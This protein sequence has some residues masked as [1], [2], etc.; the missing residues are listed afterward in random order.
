VRERQRESVC[1]PVG[2]VGM[3]WEHPQ[4]PVFVLRWSQARDAV[5]PVQGHQRRGEKVIEGELP[6]LVSADGEDSLPGG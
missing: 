2:E 3:E 5:I 4:S 6:V 1:V